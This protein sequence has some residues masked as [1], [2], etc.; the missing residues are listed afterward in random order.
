MTNVR[1]YLEHHPQIDESCYIDPAAAV[2]GEVSLAEGVSVWPFAVL[3]GDVNSITIGARSNVQDLSMLHVSH[4]TP[5]KPEGSPL[6]IGE[7]VTIGHKVMLHGCIIGNRV[8]VGMGTIILDDVVIED[9]VM[10]GAG[11]LVPPR[12]RL[13]SGYLYVGSPVKQVRALTDEEKAF[14]VYSAEH[15]MRVS[16]NHKKTLNPAG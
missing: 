6:V 7:D 3:R 13:E 4:K 2:I 14:L 1:P 8:L 11:S 16:A 5:A 9:D 10:I 15:Y 12:K